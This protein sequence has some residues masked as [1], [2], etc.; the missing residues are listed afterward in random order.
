MTTCS[1]EDSPERAAELLRLALPLMSRHQVPTNPQNIALWYEYVSGRNRG[2]MDAMDAMA[3]QGGGFDAG[4]TREL[5]SRYILQDENSLDQMREVLARLVGELQNQM[6]DAGGSLPHYVETLSRF[7]ELLGASNGRVETT[8]VT[9]VLDETRSTQANQERLRRELAVVSAE[10]DNLR[11]ELQQLREESR[12]DALT[13]VGNRRALDRAIDKALEE[14]GGAGDL[15]SILM[16]DIDNFKKFN[17]SYGHLIGDRVLRFVARVLS[18][19]IKGRDTAARYGGEEF[20]V[21]LP[22]TTLNNARMLADRIRRE[23][24]SGVLKDSSS[25]KSFGRITISIGV[26]KCKRGESRDDLLSRV[27]KAL[28]RAKQGG[29]DRVVAAN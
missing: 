23:V 17:D 19:S 10:T 13:G 7:A 25:G 11:R 27:D 8:Q 21:L 15:F 16:C 2:L 20:A 1:Y 22:G 26:A 3:G 5:F 28:Y 29:R 9:H 6:R 4:S 12:R 24:A 14:A 18:N